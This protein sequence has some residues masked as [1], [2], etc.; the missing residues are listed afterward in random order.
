MASSD[1][2]PLAERE[3]AWLL[4]SAIAWTVTGA[5]MLVV[6][7]PLWEA[8]GV[9]LMALGL[10]LAGWVV[11]RR[12]QPPR[13]PA[14]WIFRYRSARSGSGDPPRRAGGRHARVPARSR[15]RAAHPKGST[16]LPG[17]RARL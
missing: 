6:R 4:H 16:G 5:L 15:L 14:N 12:H 13:Q 2:Q 9:A 7:R 11:Q 3:L 1:P 10:G 17:G 8:V